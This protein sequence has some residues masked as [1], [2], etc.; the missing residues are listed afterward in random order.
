VVFEETVKADNRVVGQRA[1]DLD[2]SRELHAMRSGGIVW[3]GYV[4]VDGNSN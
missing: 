2:L 3:V 1:V 4:S